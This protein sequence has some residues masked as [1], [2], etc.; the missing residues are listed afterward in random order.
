MKKIIFALIVIALIGSEVLAGKEPAIKLT[1]EEEQA[2]MEGLQDANVRAIRMFLDAYHNPRKASELDDVQVGDLP[3]YKRK[4]TS[5]RFIVGAVNGFLLG[6]EIVTIIFQKS[7]N[8][9]LDVW[10]KQ[11]EVKMIKDSH[12]KPDVKKKILNS[13]APFLSRPEFGA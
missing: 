1:P 9:F 7:P 5:G 10:V 2:Y 3:R 12:I 6:G 13:V 8:V 4:D 11:G